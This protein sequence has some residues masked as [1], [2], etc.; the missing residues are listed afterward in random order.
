MRAVTKR[1]LWWIALAALTLAPVKIAVTAARTELVSDFRP[2]PHRL[3]RPTSPEL[4]EVGFDAAGEHIR[5]WLR[6]PGK[7]AA[8]V[9]LHGADADRATML[10]EAKIL[11]RHG[12][13]V[14]LYDSPG[15][16]ESSGHATWDEAE[17]AAL[18][19]ALDR[20]TI[21]PGIDP[22]R[23][24]VLG[25]S[26]G[27]IIALQVAADDLRVRAVAVTGAIPDFDALLRH[28]FRRY[29][30]LS[31]WPAVE[32]ARW[33][34]MDLDHHRPIDQIAA[35]APRPLL[36]VAGSED[37]TVPPT[38]TRALFEAAREP[39]ALFIVP[40]GHHGHYDEVAGA[41]YEQRLIAFFDEALA[42]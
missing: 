1:M 3:P 31:A 13:A 20:L 36:V 32:A 4:A 22:H 29:G 38:M 7:G 19:A 41:G 21:E 42:P 14:L 12:Y 16:G 35:I 15:H 18:R 26:M 17:R 23:L 39:K 9:L 6:A 27:S 24:G 37:A 5:G 2:T 34:G 25:F 30:P 8:V 33:A 10:P 40:G 28:Q 11:A